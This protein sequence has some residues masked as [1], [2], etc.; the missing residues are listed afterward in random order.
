MSVETI[1]GVT[2]MYGLAFREVLTNKLI[3]FWP[4]DR[5][6]SSYNLS[7]IVDWARSNVDDKTAYTIKMEFVKKQ[8]IVEAG[9]GA[10]FEGHFY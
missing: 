7:N 4:F 3:E 10:L 2:G 6:D 9:E 5:K 8:E 1:D